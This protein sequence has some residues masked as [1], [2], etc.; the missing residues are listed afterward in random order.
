MCQRCREKEADKKLKYVYKSLCIEMQRMWNLKCK[1]IPII[2]AATEIVTN[3]KQ[4]S[5]YHTRKSFIIF[6][7]KDGCTWTI[8]HNTGSTAV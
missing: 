1:I 7:T 4:K 6:T 5:K 2:I 3:F 8:T